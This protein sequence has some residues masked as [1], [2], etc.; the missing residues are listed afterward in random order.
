MQSHVFQAKQQK[1]ALWH[2]SEQ[3]LTGTAQAMQ[4]RFLEYS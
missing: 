3:L 4:E 1:T 2:I